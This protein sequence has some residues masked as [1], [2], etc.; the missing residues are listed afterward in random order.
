MK[1]EFVVPRLP[2]TLDLIPENRMTMIPKRSQIYHEYCFWLH[3]RIV[4]KCKEADAR[5]LSSVKFEFDDHAKK[6]EFQKSADPITW[7]DQNGY[8]NIS[9]EVTIRQ[10]VL[11]L[12]ADATHFLYEGLRALEKRK[13]SVAFA[14]FRKPFKENLLFLIWILAD[15]SDFY[16]RLK[17]QNAQKLNSSI[18]AEKRKEILEA[19]IKKIDAIFQIYSEDMESY[20]Y[21]RSNPISFMSLFD[22][23]THLTTCHKAYA[24]EPLNLNFIFKD[25]RDN[26]VYAPEVY[27]IIAYGLLCLGAVQSSLITQMTTINEKTELWEK[28]SAVGT[29][30]SLFVSGRSPYAQLIKKHLNPA[31]RCNSCDLKVNVTKKMLPRLLVSEK[32]YCKKCGFDGEFPFYWIVSQTMDIDID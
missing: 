27:N 28:L 11:A 23:A 22:K 26:D 9:E 2:E 20:L 29:Y 3:D 6:E 8:E 1:H 15:R 17:D 14:L 24:T 5:K 32:L 31:L 10:V 16:S 19:G 7:L 13:F 18:P 21:D 12:M 25:P 30:H 4:S